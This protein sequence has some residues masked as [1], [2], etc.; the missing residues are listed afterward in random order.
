MQHSRGEM[1]A[2]RAAVGD[3]CQA[4]LASSS[5]LLGLHASSSGQQ[6]APPALPLLQLLLLVV[7]RTVTCSTLVTA[8]EACDRIC[9][10]LVQHVISR[11]E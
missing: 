11:M 2:G 9:R 10:V 5:L 6:Q 1:H 4:A 8:A 3:L 7:V